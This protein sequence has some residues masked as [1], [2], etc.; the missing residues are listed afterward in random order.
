MNS[1]EKRQA[2]KYVEE[3]LKS[4]Y[5][6]NPNPASYYRSIEPH[7][8][9]LRMAQTIV[10]NAAEL[11]RRGIVRINGM[12]IQPFIAICNGERAV[13]FEVTNERL[14]EENR[15]AVEARAA[16]KKQADEFILHIWAGDVTW[17]MMRPYMGLDEKPRRKAPK[18][19]NITGGG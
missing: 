2:V 11:A 6:K 12:D 9:D 5:D 10:K 1:T 4:Q 15:P 7:G 16:A 17:D 19:A 18:S 14:N 13:S 8:P 3:W